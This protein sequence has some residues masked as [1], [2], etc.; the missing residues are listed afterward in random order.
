ME[1]NLEGYVKI[2]KEDIEKLRLGAWIKYVSSKGEYR[3][4]GV[5]VYNGFPDYIV[6]M[7]TDKKI[8]W[9]VNLK[10]NELYVSEKIVKDQK[11]TIKNKL[12]ELY[13]QDMLE[14]KN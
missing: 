8:R 13:T 7:N 9:S 14:L 1:K 6:L 2:N 11:N 5:L 10:Q 3:S 4:G 12:Y